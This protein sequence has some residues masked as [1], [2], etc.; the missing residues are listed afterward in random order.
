[1]S[2]LA[3]ALAVSLL[4]GFNNAKAKKDKSSFLA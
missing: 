4:S 2:S 1:V 3:L